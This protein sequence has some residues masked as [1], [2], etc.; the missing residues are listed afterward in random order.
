MVSVSID[1]PHCAVK[2]TVFDIGI[3][4]LVHVYSDHIII[5]SRTTPLGMKRIPMRP[6]RLP[7]LS[8]EVRRGATFNKFQSTDC[9][10]PRMI[11]Q[12]SLSYPLSM[13]M[14]LQGFFSPKA[15]R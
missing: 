11:L 9:K 4:E 12:S 1:E 13:S 14:S 15:S 3:Q 8:W 6:K 10:W 5:E 7:E 2:N